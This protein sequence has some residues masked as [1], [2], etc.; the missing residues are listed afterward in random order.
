MKIKILLERPTEDYTRESFVREFEVDK[1]EVV[2]GAL[3]L[4]KKPGNPWRIFN[5]SEW[6]EIAVDEDELVL[7]TEPKKPS[8]PATTGKVISINRNKD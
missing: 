8:D 5:S 2:R 7:Y 3:W 4:W 6:S 1:F